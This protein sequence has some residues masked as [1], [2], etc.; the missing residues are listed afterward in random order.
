VCSNSAS[1]LSLVMASWCTIESDPGVF[2][3]LIEQIGVKGCQ[4]EELYSLDDGVFDEI[5]PV[6]GLIF[7]FKWRAG[8]KDDRPAVDNPNLFFAN[9]VINNAC[10]TQAILSILLNCPDIEI[11]E[12]LNTFK[13]FSK[14]FPPELRGLAISNSELIRTTHNS[15]SRP[16]PFVFGQ[17]SI[18]KDDDVFHFI[19]YIPFEGNMY[20]LDGLKPGPILLGECTKD[21]W[22][23]KVRPAILKRI[24]KYSRS[25][26]RFNLM[27][28]VGNKKELYTKEIE[29]LE[30]TLSTLRPKPQ[31]DAMDVDTSASSASDAQIQQIQGQIAILKQKIAQEEEKFKSW[32][33]ENIR[34]KHNYIPFLV[35][36]LKIL[37]E[38]GELMPLVQKAKQQAKEKGSSRKGAAQ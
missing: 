31:G 14:D 8:D 7:L 23:E 26:I 5:K 15:F 24:E 29:A 34:R 10:A 32:K 37:A 36:L 9:Q 19:S 18:E 21:N 6:F 38:K 17:K 27:A 3:E 2:T 13:S 28:I 25:E 20:E 1:I 16:E 30:R 22:L 12:E 35:N 11:G 33:A 4:V